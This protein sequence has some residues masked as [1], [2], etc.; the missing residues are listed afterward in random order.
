MTNSETP[1]VLPPDAAEKFLAVLR[2]V[3]PD[4][5]TIISAIPDAFVRIR[6]EDS[7]WPHSDR[8]LRQFV[9]RQLTAEERNTLS[10]L[11]KNQVDINDLRK[12]KSE[13][14]M[15]VGNPERRSAF[16]TDVANGVPRVQLAFRHH[17]EINVLPV[18]LYEAILRE[19]YIAP[20][21]DANR[22][23]RHKTFQEA[24]EYRV[25]DALEVVSRKRREWNALR[26]STM[27]SVSGTCSPSGS[28]WGVINDEEIA[29]LATL[30]AATRKPSRGESDDIAIPTS[31]SGGDDILPP[32]PT[33]KVRPVVNAVRHLRGDK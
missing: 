10:T 16:L 18:L 22:T 26:D 1:I 14:E 17:V 27:D 8:K 32:R 15:L 20:L 33:G 13:F 9:S 12:K 30:R 29:Q 4:H 2:E 6:R 24:L 25:T 5:D 7:A 21:T 31:F 3:L 11:C 19:R 23:E 28:T